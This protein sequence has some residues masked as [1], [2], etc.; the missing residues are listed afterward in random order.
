MKNSPTRM[1]DS[2]R[3]LLRDGLRGDISVTYMGYMMGIVLSKK[4]SV[5]YVWNFF[6]IYECGDIVIVIK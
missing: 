1:E 6:F 2:L 3:P 4:T 5:I